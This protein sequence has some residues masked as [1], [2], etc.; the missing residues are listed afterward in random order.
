MFYA[1][2]DPKFDTGDDHWVESVSQVRLGERLLSRLGGLS[3]CFYRLALRADSVHCNKLNVLQHY[4]L[5]R[6]ELERLH[7]LV[8]NRVVAVTAFFP[9]SVIVSIFAT[10]VLSFLSGIDGAGSIVGPI[11]SVFMLVGT[12]LSL[13]LYAGYLRRILIQVADSISLLSDLRKSLCLEY[14][15]SFGGAQGIL[16]E[17]K[18]AVRGLRVRAIVL[19]KLITRFYGARRGSMQYEQCAR[20]SLWLDW[21]A[22][23]PYDESRVHGAIRAC[24]V[25]MPHLDSS[26]LWKTPD[27]SPL[28]KSADPV[29]FGS[30]SRLQK[31]VAIRPEIS[32]ITTFLGLISA[33]V[34][35]FTKLI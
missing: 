22:D 7:R 33:A 21:V 13:S 31:L 11:S 16:Y 20:L 4:Q 26:E 12:G 17:R 32:F 29:G 24:K 35:L 28:P 19:R 9:A 14:S 10:M 6:S 2:V 27:L 5:P 3:R 1:R 18:V 34:V 15:A 25:M 30:P 8:Y 23:D